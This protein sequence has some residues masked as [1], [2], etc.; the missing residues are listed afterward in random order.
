MT[1]QGNGQGGREHGQKADQLPGYR[2]LADPA[3][4]AHVAAVWGIDPDELPGPGVSAYELLDRLGTD[5]GVRALLVAAS[6]PVVSAPN[7]RHV[8]ERLDALDFLVVADFFLSETARRAD[9]VLPTTQWAEE[10]GTMTNV[11]GRILLRRKA[12]DP[13][14]GARSDLGILHGIAA[15]LGRGEFFPTEPAAVFAELGRASA[16]G[17][18]DYAGITLDRLRAGEQLFW[19][20]PDPGHPGTPRM[21]LDS[22]A[23][24]D[25]RARFV[26]VTPRPAVERPTAEYPYL[27]TTGRSRNHYQ[28]GTQTR[29]SPSLDRIEPTPYVELHPE[30]ARAIGVVDGGSARLHTPRGSAVL[31]ARTTPDIRRDTVF[32]PFHWGGAA[33]VNALTSD[34]LDPTSRMP[35]FKTCP[36]AVQPD[37]PQGSTPMHS[38]P[39]FLQGIFDFE[40]RGA[41]KPALLH[42]AIESGALSYTVP[43]GVITQPL[44]FR[45]GNGTDELVTVVL[46]RDGAPMRYFPIGA[47]ASCHVALAVVEDIEDGSVLELQLAAPEGLTGSVVVDLGLV[48]V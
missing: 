23:T 12:F 4:R 37:P 19:P 38:T 43:A 5:G 21:F 22:F 27:L 18:A 2:K 40:G 3:D 7:A 45:G 31:R 42:G 39:R 24:P 8:T 16:G 41:D 46:V 13:P 20:C 47:R 33:A 6:N 36:V 28:S 17:A 15:R 44:Y 10:D 9:V 14:G 11:E 48:E 30:L 25:G 26:P 35:E 29:R 34:A 1:G 32:V